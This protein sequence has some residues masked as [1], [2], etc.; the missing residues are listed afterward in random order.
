MNSCT[1]AK[2]K[3]HIFYWRC[4][5]TRQIR[6]MRNPADPSSV[7]GRLTLRGKELTAADV[8]R[9]KQLRDKLEA[10]HG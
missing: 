6:I 7:V 10:R 5:Q 8:R 1:D 4:N 2:A 3:L 9:A